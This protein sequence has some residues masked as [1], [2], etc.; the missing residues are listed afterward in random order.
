VDVT[1]ITLSP[2]QAALATERVREAGLA[3]H[4]HVRVADWREPHG[5]PFDAVAS[6]GMVEH[7]GARSID[8]YARRLAALLRPGGRVL[9]QGIARVRASDPAAAGPFTQHFIFPDGETL[10]LARVQLAFE[11]AGLVT[12][13][14]EGFAADYAETLRHWARRL[15]ERLEE[16][17]AIAGRE[18]VRV[19][20]LYLRV[21]RRDFERG[22][23]SVYQV[24]ARRP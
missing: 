12:E 22:Y 6:I 13:H 17:V 1:G 19:W 21:A 16:A 8:A 24:L 5:E 10:H 3:D 15:D 23:R 4:V 9:N 2:P 11:R 7:V 18:R 20:R 14:V